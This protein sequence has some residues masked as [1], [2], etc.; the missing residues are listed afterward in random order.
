MKISEFLFSLTCSAKNQVTYFFLNF[1]IQ[2]NTIKGASLEFFLLQ[3]FFISRKKWKF[4]PFV[5]LTLWIANSNDGTFFQGTDATLCSPVTSF[6]PLGELHGKGTPYKI[7]TDI[8]TLWLN[9]PSRPIQWKS[10][11]SL[12]N[13]I[14]FLFVWLNIFK[15]S[16]HINWKSF[17]PN[18]KSERWALISAITWPNMTR[19]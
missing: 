5:M 7:R 18:L 10:L 3:Y 15:I 6:V 19:L 11:H 8:A 17:W 2:R 14:H 12:S 16:Y 1:R 13:K 9:R 4:L